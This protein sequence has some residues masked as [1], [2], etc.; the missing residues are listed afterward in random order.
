VPGPATNI[1]DSMVSEI[2]TG[3]QTSQCRDFIKQTHGV[4]SAF[5]HAQIY[6]GSAI[7][8]TRRSA[9]RSGRSS[10][11]SPTRGR[12][13]ASLMRPARRRLQVHAVASE[14]EAAGRQVDIGLG[15][16]PYRAGS[17]SAWTTCTGSPP[18]TSR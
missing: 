16:N 3:Y 9:K 14:L 18:L 5:A 1:S 11:V 17:S 13:T 10:S 12:A 2:L 7:S 6:P 15:F 8:R 4:P